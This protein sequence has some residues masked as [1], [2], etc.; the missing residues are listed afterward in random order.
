MRTADLRRG[1]AE[2]GGDW[3]REGAGSL[4][5][6]PLC[7]CSCCF[8]TIAVCRIARKPLAR[9]ET[10]ASAPPLAYRLPHAIE[11]QHLGGGLFAPL[12]DR[13]RV[14]RGAPAR[15]GRS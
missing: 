13:G 1:I 7:N 6:P 11:I 8:R 5:Y 4:Q 2:S 9:P 14:R 12:P 3:R 15:R 10:L